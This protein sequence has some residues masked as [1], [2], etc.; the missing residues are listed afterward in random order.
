MNTYVD[1][2]ILVKSYATESNSVE[3]DA[4]ILS[5]SSP[6]PLTHFQELE[7][8]NAIRLKLSRGELTAGE[9]RQALNDFQADIV[10]TRGVMRVRC[11]S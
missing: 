10:S 4:I 8:R 3:A 1:T 9:M 5:T 2:G 7:L 11:M 6:L